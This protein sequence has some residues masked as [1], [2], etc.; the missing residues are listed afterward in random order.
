[1]SLKWRVIKKS[2]HNRFQIVS[3]LI[4]PRFIYIDH[5]LEGAS[6]ADRFALASFRLYG[7]SD[8]K[9]SQISFAT[10]SADKFIS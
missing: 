8:E 1:M 4:H 10:C 9:L 2:T 7:Q 5:Y 3:C 6:N